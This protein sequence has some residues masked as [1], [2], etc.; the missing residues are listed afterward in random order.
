LLKHIGCRINQVNR[1]VEISEIFW[2]AFVFLAI[3]W[4]KNDVAILGKPKG[5]RPA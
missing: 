3:E 1:M 2:A 5:L 4:S